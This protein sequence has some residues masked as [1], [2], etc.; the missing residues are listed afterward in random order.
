M[1]V[2]KLSEDEEKSLKQR[3]EKIKELQE[4]DICFGCY[5]FT[6]GDIFPDDGLIFY[7]DEKVRCQ[8]EKYP[9][10]TGQTIIVSKEHY[11][12]ISEM[13]LE[14]G[15]YILKISNAIIN[16]HKE[17][18]GAEK[19]YMCTICDGKRNHLH[20]QLFP[21]LKGEPRGYQNFVR[22]EGILMDYKEEVELYKC[23]MKELML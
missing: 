6:T 19:V 8:F 22:E 12:D 16:L 13:P 17:I 7:E 4:K 18:I 9:R 11:E 5:N 14:L 15:T 23:R 21:R 10:A 3:F 20:F 1:Y 2:K